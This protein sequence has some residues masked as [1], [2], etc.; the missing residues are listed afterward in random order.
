MVHCPGVLVGVCLSYSLATPKAKLFQTIGGISM[1]LA[2]FVD[3]F[4]IQFVPAIALFVILMAF[5]GS[6]E[7]WRTSVFKS[8]AALVV[9]F[10]IVNRAR[11]WLGLSAG[12][13]NLKIDLLSQ[14]WPLLKNDC[15]P[16]LFGTKLFAMGKT[17][18]DVQPGPAWFDL[19]SPYAIVIP[20][21]A[22]ASGALLFFVKSIPYQVRILGAFGSA[23]ATTCTLGFLVSPAAVDLLGARL[24]F[25]ILLTFPLACAPL[26]YVLPSFRALV[27]LLLP[28]LVTA[29]VGSWLSYGIMVNGIKPVTNAEASMSEDVALGKYLRAQNIQYVGANYWLAYRLAFILEENPIF[30]PM[31][32]EDRYPKWRRE[33]DAQTT[34]AYVSHPLFSDFDVGAQ[35][36]ESV[37]LGHQ[38][39]RE[40]VSGFDVLVVRKN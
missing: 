23:V 1:M 19:I 31:L 26:A 37:K 29:V 11:V 16:W 28:Y 5:D 38:V 12:R 33:F 35:E 17:N 10:I 24:L 13:S 15:V 34:V 2:C 40:T 7:Q 4:A 18:F 9:G 3:L 21:L 30:V 36:V 32:S 27:A 6:K 39:H 20:L 14:N 8:I 22:I 25:P